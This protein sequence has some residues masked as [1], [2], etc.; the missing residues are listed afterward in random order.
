MDQ[1]LREKPKKFNCRV[2]KLSSLRILVVAGETWGLRIL[3]EYYLQNIKSDNIFI[4][5]FNLHHEQ[6]QQIPFHQKWR[7]TLEW[8]QHNND[9]YVPESK[10]DRRDH[11]KA[12]VTFIYW[13]FLLRRW[14]NAITVYYLLVFISLVVTKLQLF[15][16]LNGLK[17]SNLENGLPAIIFY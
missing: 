4:F 14:Y 5:F 1:I 7:R 13:N 15:F 16:L 17:Y 9:S 8:L 3:I 11:M 2:R 12:F 10:L 6:Q